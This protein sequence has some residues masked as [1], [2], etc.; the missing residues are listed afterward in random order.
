MGG[1]YIRR[2]G[3]R[4]VQHP[5]YQS[6]SYAQLL[7]DFATVVEDEAMILNCVHSHNMTAAGDLKDPFYLTIFSTRLHS[8]VLKV[9]VQR[10]YLFKI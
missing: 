6:W 9:H 1:Q 3:N 10:L 4:D 5:S 2:R 8:L 7:R